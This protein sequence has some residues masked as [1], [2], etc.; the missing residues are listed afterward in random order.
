L[1][2]P[3]LTGSYVDETLSGVAEDND[4]RL[5]QA[6]AGTRLDAVVEFLSDGWGARE[7]VGL[8]GGTDADWDAFS[9]QWDGYLHVSAAAQRFATVSDDASR[10]WIDLDRDG[11]FEP[12]ERTDNHWGG[13]QA[14]RMGDRTGAVPA[15]VYAVRIQYYEGG[16]SNR[17][18][19]ASAPYVPN[20]FV[21]TADNPVQTV[22]VIVLSFDP[23]VPG[24]GNR[25]LHEAFGWNDPHELAGQ[26]EA[27]M[28]WATGGAID[29][30]IVEWRDLDAFPTFTDGFRYNPDEYMQFRRENQGWHDTGTDFYELI[31]SQELLP[32]INAGAVDEIWTFGDHYFSLLGEAWMG[33]P[34]SFFIN[35]PSFPDAGFDRAIA[36]YGFSWERGVAEMIHN[37][38]HRT[39]NHGQ[40]AFGSWNLHDPVTAF[41]RFSSNYLDTGSGPY[42]VGTCHVPANA[43][44]HY[45]YGDPRTVDSFAADF[46]NYPSMTYATQP[47]SRET[48]AMGPE[49][50]YHRDFMN[51]YFSM[52]PRADGT[53]ADG[54]AAN[55]LKY[56][57]DFNSYEST[58]GLGREED[59]FAAGPVVRRAGGTTYDLTVRYY[60]GTAVD[61][62]SL[63]AGD[64]RVVAPGGF[65]LA[66]VAVAVGPEVHTTAGTARTVTYTIEPPGGAWD[67]QDNGTYRIELLGGEV[68]DTEANAFP[69]GQVGSFRVALYDPATINIAAMLAAGTASAT[70]TPFDH[71]Q[72]G[73]LFDGNT[74]TLAR[75]PSIDPAV[76]TLEFDEPE[77]VTGFRA[78][79]SHAGG[80][81]AYQYEVEAADSLADL[82]GRTGSYRLLVPAT[83]TPSDAYSTVT[84]DTA[85]TARLFRLTATRLTGDNYVH[86]NEWSLLGTGQAEADAP[87]AELTSA[88][89]AERGGTAHFLD[90]TFTD[91]TAV[92]VPSI[93]NGDLVITGPDGATITPTFYDID[94]HTDGTVRTATFWFIPP[95]GAWD[96]LDNGTYRIEL[97]A[98][99]VRDVLYNANGAP[100]LLGELAVSIPAPQLRPP[101]DLAE[102]NAADWI[103]WADGGSASTHDDASRTVAGGA[104][105]RF[106]TDGGF[107]TSGTV[108]P[109][110]D[111]DWDVTAATE[112]HFHVYA[113]NPN[114]AFQEGPWVRLNGVDGSFFEYRYYEGG[115]PATPLND[116]IG[117]WVEFVVP[118]EPSGPPV[119]PTGWRRTESGAPDL[120]HIASVE[121]HADTWGGGFTLWLDG[122]GFDLPDASVV[123][124]HVFYNASAFDGFNPAADEQDDEA[125]A[126]DKHA[127]LPG[128]PASFANSTSYSR[129][130]NGIL[131]DVDGLAGSPAESDFVFKVSDTGAAGTWT[132]A[133]APINDIA[134]DVRYGAGIDGSDRV[135]ILWA[136]GAVAGC[137][138]E[139]TVLSNAH[140]GALG[141]A[142][143]D[144]FRFGNLPGETGADA[145]VDFWDFLAVK[146]R[147]GTAP[148]GLDERAD[149]DRNG[150]VDGGDLSV[151]EAAFGSSLEMPAFASAGA[152]EPA[153][154]AA[155]VPDDEALPAPV[156][157]R[158]AEPMPIPEPMSAD[159]RG[160]PARQQGVDLL[161]AS[162]AIGRQLPG[163]SGPALEIRLAIPDRPAPPDPSNAERP[164][165][166][167]TVTEQAGS[168][169][170]RN[171]GRWDREP[172]APNPLLP[173]RLLDE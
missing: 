49:P 68:L 32:L 167:S 166:R 62:A 91:A 20:A 136:D 11:L 57:W 153:V 150:S 58:T 99:A 51:W 70:H 88:G 170:A 131:I 24:E 15:G 161:S 142:E 100:Q 10:I 149:L 173:L 96:Y 144:V 66:P 47:V 43:D 143:D 16:G 123:G 18:S 76:V 114:I 36:G 139:V 107:D 172:L 155:S 61:G 86:V 21:P 39:E 116:A 154:Q 73:N 42:G 132:Q 118:L 63:D 111:A 102:D 169:R 119:E 17:F 163:G 27:D 162:A 94:E 87:T 83:G 9:V 134:A 121:F 4:W 133:P 146:A 64:V 126:P 46:A 77:T 124:R 30:Q 72:V 128:E 159:P 38:C 152:T 80:D 168:N 29:F 117:R 137:W 71:G 3:G 164:T 110:G 93:A 50:D 157:E 12:S 33:G 56:I 69:G 158:T 127:L 122:V 108:P 41:D 97:T 75:T 55:W 115:H 65:L 135:T 104:S 109:A 147:L 171:L 103:A 2:V 14:E 148:A 140:G 45:D 40:R 6:I 8:T 59:A 151:L 156:Q 52:I 1:T 141:L 78:F 60:D 13:I 85:H 89:V 105:V 82:D 34:N 106:E 53:D 165:P 90:V 92:D 113:E 7:E 22:R 5:T 54:R 160:V 19:L 120:A 125:L 37:L 130:L 95:G 44:G 74:S 101:A 31:E 79:F 112:L 129:G 81:P 35:G 25:L 67:P 48:W 145:A 84:L 26:F 138:L 98:G 23:R 28:E